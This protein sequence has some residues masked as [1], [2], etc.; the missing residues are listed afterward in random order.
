[1]TGRRLFAFG[2][3]LAMPLAFAASAQVKI[4]FVTTLS[5]AQSVMGTPMRDGA[6]L[7]MEMLGNKLGGLPAEIIFADDQQK[8]DVERQIAERFIKQDHVDFVTGLLASNGL[9]AIVQPL[10][11]SRTIL[12]SANAGPHELAGSQCSPYFFSVS[13]ENDEPAQAMGAY[14]TEQKIDDVYLMAPN[15]A[16]GKDMLAGFKSTFKGHVVGEAYTA[17]GQ[18][19]YQAEISQIQ[20]ASPKAIFVFYPGGMG[21]QFTKQYAQS[22]V[23]ERIP[24]YSVN[25]VDGS[26]LP[27]VQDAADGNYEASDWAATLQNPRSLMFV[28]AF[29]KKYGYV[30]PVYAARSFDAIYLIDSTVRAVAGNLADKPALA[31]AMEK[32]DFPSV[33]GKFAFNTNHFPIE[34]FHI[35]Q[36]EK[37]DGAWTM[38]IRQTI[39]KDYKDS[40]ASECQMKPAG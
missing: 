26:S 17:F 3:L 15:Y 14:M 9:L 34:D 6:N 22:G 35:L 40:F 29:R 5:G 12:I 23:R 37:Q 38:Q 30:P 2:F 8:P 11:R 7:A 33:K 25:T 18:L 20:A 27:S 19:D 28:D 36:I 16:A 24:M 10:T 4:G 31:A 32:A 13:Q 21:I 39:F 1:M